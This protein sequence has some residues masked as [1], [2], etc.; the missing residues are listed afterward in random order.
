M[1]PMGTSEA[2]QI[3]TLT[4]SL[5]LGLATCAK[6]EI[7]TPS[8]S[9]INA[10]QKSQMVAQVTQVTDGD[11]IKVSH[12]G[13]ATFVVRLWGVDAPELKQPFG[14]QAWEMTEG[15]V[16]NTYVVVNIVSQDRY[17]R[18]V[19]KVTMSGGGDLGEALVQ[20]GLAWWYQAYAKDAYTLQML[21]TQ[22]A[23]DKR[24]LWAGK[25]EALPTPPW[26]WRK[27]H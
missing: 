23:R 2:L 11:T 6:T 22:A 7:A 12:G 13:S 27:A 18:L 8:H 15:L 16:L 5:V 3:A 9:G 17:G 19:A 25:G 21:E 1:H 10:Q 26:E 20:S 4:L 14:P 24:G